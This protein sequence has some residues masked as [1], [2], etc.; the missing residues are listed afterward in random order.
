MA[1]PQWTEGFS[2]QSC[3]GICRGGTFSYG[4]HESQAWERVPTGG[5]FKDFSLSSDGDTILLYCMN[6]DGHPHFLNGY[7]FAE[8]GWA[9]PGLSAD[10]YG[11]ARSALPEAL[12]TQGSVALPHF[13]NYVFAADPRGKTRADLLT[14]FANAS[15]YMG[16]NDQRWDIPV[17]NQQTSGALSRTA[18]L[19]ALCT[20]AFAGFAVIGAQL[21]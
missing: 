15:N 7:T 12:E 16:R 5:S 2:G 6:A 20:A 3:N 1:I 4:F 9:E 17:L 14:V 10:E 8:G 13:N 18:S 19:S 21:L 11:T